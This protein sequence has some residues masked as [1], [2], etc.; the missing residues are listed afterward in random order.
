MARCTKQEAQITRER[1]LDAAERVFE[2]RGVARTSLAEIAQAAGVTRGALYWH[3][4]DKAAL[5]NAMLDRVALPLSAELE[6]LLA[7]VECLEAEKSDYLHAIDT[8]NCLGKRS[9]S[10]R[11]LT[12]GHL[13]DL[14]GISPELLDM[15]LAIDRFPVVRQAGVQPWLD[16]IT[17]RWPRQS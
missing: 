17:A 13:V 3:F 2:A 7:C 6:A 14:Y 12:W 15:T 8:E 9:G 16:Q 4:K 5:F 11:A 1:L 10:T